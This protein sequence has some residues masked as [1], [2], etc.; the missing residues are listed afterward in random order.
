MVEKVVDIKVNGKDALATLKDINSTIDEQRE[1]LVMLEEEYMKAKKAL[2]DYNKSGKVNLSQEAALKKAL[3]ERKD[4]LDDQRLGLKKLAVEQRAANAQVKEFREGQKD[5]TNI[6]RGIDKL[7]GGFATKIVKLKK[8][9]LSGLK[10]IKAFNLGLSGMK[11]ALIATGI[12]ALVVLVGVLIANFD[13]LKGLMSGVSAESKKAAEN[14]KAQAEESQDALDTLESSENILRAQGKSEKEIL[15]MKKKQTDEV[16]AN[17]TAQLEAQKAIKDAQVQ[18]AK[19]NSKIL[20]GILDF[21][22]TPITT[23][24]KT[25]DAIG[26][27][28]GKN[29][30]LTKK[31]KDFTKEVGKF[32][33]S[34]ED[35]DLDNEIK[36]T[37]KKLLAIQ[38]KRA[39]YDLQEKKNQKKHNDDLEKEEEEAA[40]KLAELKEKIRVANANKEAEARQ[41]ELDDIKAAN[42]EL[43]KEAEAAGL[44]TEELE[45]SL[46]ER[47]Q[48][49]KDE[50]AQQD[51]EREE[52]R[53]KEEDQ[54]KKEESEKALEELELG[55]EFDQLNFEE[56]R[57]LINEREALLLDDKR[58]SD[59]HRTQLEQEFADA[60]TLISQKEA[61]AK[62]ASA[63]SF[64]TSL[65]KVGDLV[66]KETQAG[67]LASSAAALIQTYLA[68]QQARTSQLAIP[69]P[70]APA[71][72]AIAMAVEIAAG[73]KN[74]K[75]I[76]STKVPRASGGGAPPV[77]AT[78]T[79]AP[80][81]NI[82]GT[83][84]TSQLAD[85]VAGQMSE[86]VQAYVVAQ[87]VT[88]AQS[89]ENGIIEGA[90]I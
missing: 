72:A 89:L 20:T 68:A 88:T 69:T 40:R 74:V 8:G 81:F 19:R 51:K 43:L 60:R 22:L 25:I 34:G 18:T 79:R 76:N 29:L 7:T 50:F 85:S 86:P 16:I 52:K 73:L 83:S 53:Q 63:M 27:K 12:G 65:N 15:E 48:A 55:K 2:D 31:I 9:F 42:E 64:A 1:I 38:N 13:K 23:L 36:E 17:L 58:I 35:E 37:E 3:K 32:T 66:G 11:K 28:L 59:E 67:K 49:K 57:N 44:R 70:D 33:F 41:K 39:G 84:E 21:L 45:T 4:A 62:A 5:Q 71:R 14:A 87:D 90:S 61:A 82:V 78:V 75:E 6:I 56:A 54:K 26:A 30:G 80:S 77:P 24:T 46:A 47:L 10:G